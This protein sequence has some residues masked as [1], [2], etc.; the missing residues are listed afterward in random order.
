MNDQSLE[1]KNLIQ[2]LDIS[3]AEAFK[4]I[5]YG[6]KGDWD[7]FVMNSKQNNFQLLTRGA[8]QQ[9]Q[10]AHPQKAIV[11]LEKFQLYIGFNVVGNAAHRQ[12]LNYTD[13][14]TD[15]SN[16]EQENDLLFSNQ[17][18]VLTPGDENYSSE[19]D[20]ANMTQRAVIN[21]RNNNITFKQQA[22]EYLKT[23]FSHLSKAAFDRIIVLINPDA[24]REG[25]RPKK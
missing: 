16:L 9:I 18:D 7:F 21:K 6:I 24:N 23:H 15:Q 19:L 1:S 2:L 10:N 17:R 5:S 20:I 12:N 25:G 8:L 11:Y 14:W 3:E 22:I 4:F 13:L